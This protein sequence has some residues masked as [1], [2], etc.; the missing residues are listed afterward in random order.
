[1]WS[2]FGLSLKVLARKRRQ[3]HPLRGVQEKERLVR[4]L[5]GMPLEELLALLQ[6][7]H[8][9]LLHVEIRR[10]EPLTTV[11]GVVVVRKFRLINHPGRRNRDAVAIHKGIQPIGVWTAHRSKEPVKAPMDRGI[12]NRPTVVDPLHPL[13]PALLD[14]FSLLVEEGHPDVPLAGQ[15]RRVAF[16]LQHARKRQPILLDQAR[17]A[18][19]GE[20]TVNAGS[21]RHPSGQQTVP[22]RCADGRRTMGISE[23]HALP[24]QSVQMR[25]GHF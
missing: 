10:D 24:G 23:H 8:V 13:L 18:D 19:P 17:S 16:L 3:M 15:R 6:E 2:G 5:P 25:R 21:K 14:W 22:G 11:S 12:R 1:M 7:D 4:T 9:H 20:D